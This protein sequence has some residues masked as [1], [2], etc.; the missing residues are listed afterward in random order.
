MLAYSDIHS[1]STRCLERCCYLNMRLIN[2]FTQ[3]AKKKC[4]STQL[5]TTSGRVHGT[6]LSFLTISP[7][8]AFLNWLSSLYFGPIHVNLKQYGRSTIVLLSSSISIFWHETQIVENK[9]TTKALWFIFISFSG[10]WIY[11]L[12]LNFYLNLFKLTFK[13]QF[14]WVTNGVMKGDTFSVFFTSFF[15]YYLI[16][17]RRARKTWENSRRNM[18]RYSI[19]WHDFFYQFHVWVS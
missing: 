9:T 16:T 3:E 11:L 5:V 17:R 18:R 7:H 4:G 14:E 2:F 13:L 12:D 19:S 8:V 10:T 15:L 1:T 6:L